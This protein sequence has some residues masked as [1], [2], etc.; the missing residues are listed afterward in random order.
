MT[1]LG[2]AG[3]GARRLACQVSARDG[4]MECWWLAE[5]TDWEEEISISISDGERAASAAWLGMW[6]VGMRALIHMELGQ[7]LA[8]CC[9]Q[10]I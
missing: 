8:S 6:G 3:A 4:R 7:E 5:V 2:R 10:R 1:E 9:V